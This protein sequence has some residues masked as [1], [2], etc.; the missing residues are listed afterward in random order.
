MKGDLPST[1]ICSC[2]TDGVPTFVWLKHTAKSTHCMG[3]MGKKM[4]YDE[5]VSEN[6]ENV[7]PP[8]GSAE[9]GMG[10]DQGIGNTKTT[11][12]RWISFWTTGRTDRRR[13]R[14]ETVPFV[15]TSERKQLEPG[16]ARG[17]LE[18]QESDPILAL[19]LHLSVLH[20]QAPPTPPH[21]HG[22]S[23]FFLKMG[24]CETRFFPPPVSSL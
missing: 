12:R 24:S 9:D 2:E 20:S 8:W 5:A 21:S 19:T 22:S 3:G 15:L 4:L 10:E 16:S 14:G 18:E 13:V 11:L 6:P 17:S 7:C 23:F 1:I